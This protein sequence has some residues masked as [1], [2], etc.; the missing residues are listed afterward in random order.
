MGSRLAQIWLGL[1]F[2]CFGQQLFIRTYYVLGTMPRTGDKS[3]FGYIFNHFS[4][5]VCINHHFNKSSWVI[6]GGFCLMTMCIFRVL[7]LII[8][9]NKN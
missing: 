9:T 3:N 8:V 1:T 5:H 6:I 2:N 4:Q 7:N